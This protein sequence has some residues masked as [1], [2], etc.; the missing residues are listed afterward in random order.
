[1]NPLIAVV[2]SQPALFALKMLG[3]QTVTSR[4]ISRRDVRFSYI[5]RLLIYIVSQNLSILLKAAEGLRAKDSDAADEALRCVANALLLVEECRTT[6][7]EIQGADHCLDLLEKAKSTVLIFLSSRILFLCTASSSSP[8]LQTLLNG[9][10]TAGAGM[11]KDKQIA[12]TRNDIVVSIASQLDYVLD[13]VRQDMTMCKEAMTDL[14]KF[15]FNLLC[16]WP[17]V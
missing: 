17:K 8:Y 6:W 1:M 13:C 2:D 16:H 12:K 9:T 10:R 15:S 5:P 4:V 3:R 14:L 7:V 11:D